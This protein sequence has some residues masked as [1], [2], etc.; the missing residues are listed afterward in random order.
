MKSVLLPRP[1]GDDGDAPRLAALGLEV[2]RDPYVEVVE[3]RGRE[4][5]VVRSRL[6]EALVGPGAILV[7][8]SA[9]AV[10][11]L[12]P[13]GPGSVAAPVA[14]VGAAT[15]EAC[16][17]LGFEDVRIPS[18][19]SSNAA[20]LELLSAM[21]P[22]TAVMPQSSAAPHDLPQALVELGWNVASGVTYE[23]KTVGSVPPSAERLVAGGFTAVVVRSG[24]A[25]RALA[26]FVRTWP[27]ATAVIAAGEPTAEAL[28]EA[29]IPVT[30]VAHD[31]GAEGVVAAVAALLVGS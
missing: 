19:G 30:S 23:V 14:A 3:L 27:P 28:R 16:R 6:L 1:A 25:A 15:A 12:F 11:S 8:T 29:A 20:L 7:A 21:P 4:A 9:R 10:T 26:S 13:K 17:M 24:S 22:G 31:P 5:D 18:I 2:V